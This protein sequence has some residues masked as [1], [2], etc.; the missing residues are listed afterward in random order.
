MEK[1]R[2]IK[3]GSQQKKKE[4]MY[5]LS[6]CSE[7]KSKFAIKNIHFCKM[8]KQKSMDRLISKSK[9][10]FADEMKLEFQFLPSTPDTFIVM[11][12]YTKCCVYIVN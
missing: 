9:S 12:N 4:Q 5:S 6:I 2:E 3:V 11:K 7:Q 10:T 8:N 1:K